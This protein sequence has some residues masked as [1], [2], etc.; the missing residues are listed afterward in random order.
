MMLI[1]LYGIV[2]ADA[3]TPTDLHGIDGGAVRLVQAGDVAAVV[4]D[5]PASLYEESSLNARLDDLAWV[6]ARGLAHERVLDWFAMQGPVVP[7]SLFSLHLDES[8]LRERVAADADGFGR[9][10]NR[11]RGR[12][13]W[14]VRLWRREEEVLAGVEGVSPSLSA[15]SREIEEAAPGNRHPL[16]RKRETMRQ[17]EVRAASKRIAHELFAELR[18]RSDGA[19]S[20]PLPGNVAGGERALLL[21][22]AFL[23]PDDGFPEFQA[24]LGGYAGRLAGTGFELELTGPWP[25]YNF[26]DVDDA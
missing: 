14:G 1:Y 10:L 13:E 4:S 7:L 12:R 26:A 8:R 9:S 19:R 6:G 11:L 5:V 20:V 25:P 15:M 21:D 23:V 16:E 17:E 18:D 3:P 2:P 22:G 24:A